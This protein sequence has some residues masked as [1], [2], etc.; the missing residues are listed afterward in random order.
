[1]EDN[2]IIKLYIGGDKK[3]S[4]ML[5]EKYK[6]SLYNFCCHLEKN[7][8]D[9]DELFQNTWIKVFKNIRSFNMNMKFKNW[10]FAVCINTYKDEYRKKKRWFKIIKTYFNDDKKNC[11]FEKYSDDNKNTYDE[12]IKNEDLKKLLECVKALDENFKVPIILF[13]FEEK[14]YS[15][16]SGILNIPEGTVKSRLNHAKCK[17][18]TMMEGDCDER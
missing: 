5:V 2:E 13:Y 7:S 14:S 17:L 1:M 3:A 12:I 4:S 16:I 6:N 15:E 10:L 18:K 9:G 8:G 11:D